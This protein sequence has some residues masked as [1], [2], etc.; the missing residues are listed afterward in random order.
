[1]PL[2]TFIWLSLSVPGGI[3]ILKLWKTDLRSNRN[4]IIDEL[5]TR[6]ITI[7]LV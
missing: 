7:H 3:Y 5:S 1:M 2:I 4:K 6:S